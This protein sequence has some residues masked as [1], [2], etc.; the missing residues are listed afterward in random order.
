MLK[1]MSKSE[2]YY[3]L[4]RLQ[5]LDEDDTELDRKMRQKVNEEIFNR[6]TELENLR[7]GLKD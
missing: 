4:L 7:K 1:D 3:W 2:L 6:L 5:D